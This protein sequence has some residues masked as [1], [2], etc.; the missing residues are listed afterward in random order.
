MRIEGDIVIAKPIEEVFDFVADERNEPKYNR[1]MTSAEM[2]TPDPIGVGT[3]FRAM[4]T[5]RGVAVEL[6][7]EFT[8]SSAHIGSPSRPTCPPWTSPAGSSSNRS[9]RAPG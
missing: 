9:G 5:G 2:M 4:M 8:G 7:T 1:Q 6:T 3:K